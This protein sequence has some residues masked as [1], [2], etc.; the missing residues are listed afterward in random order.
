MRNCRI[1]THTVA[2]FL[3]G[4][5]LLHLIS[6]MLDLNFALWIAKLLSPLSNSAE[7][8]LLLTVILLV[9]T[10]V[11]YFW[12]KNSRSVWSALLVPIPALIIGFLSV[13]AVCLAV[14]IVVGFITGK[15]WEILFAIAALLVIGSAML[16][17][18]YV[19]V[20]TIFRIR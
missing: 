12:G 18:I 17:P 6:R 19:F 14:A 16:A 15:I 5:V 4:C 9:P 8:W 10:F 3:T 13:V 2:G 1:I 7:G 11:G 20:G